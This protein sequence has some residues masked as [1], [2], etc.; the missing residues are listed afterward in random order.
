MPIEFQNPTFMPLHWM[1]VQALVP[2][3]FHHA[4]NVNGIGSEKI[5][6]NRIWSIVLNEVT[7]I[8]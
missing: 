4:S 2:R 6:P 3:L 5:S 7:M 8:T 1:P